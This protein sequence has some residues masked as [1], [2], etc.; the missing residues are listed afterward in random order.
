MPPA[1]PQIRFS[2][3]L[4]SWHHVV[5]DSDDFDPV[6]TSVA[7]YSNDP[8]GYAERYAGHLLDRPARF[9]SS[10]PQPS[11]IL[12]LGCGPGRDLALF[13]EAGHRPVGVEMNPDFVE[14]ARA[15]GEV[16]HADFRTI[17]QIFDAESFDGVWAQA[18]L[19]HLPDHEVLSVLADLRELLNPKGRLFACVPAIGTSGWAD[20]SDGRRWYTV[21][22][23]DTFLDAIRSAG[24][25]IDDVAYG[26][27]VEVWATAS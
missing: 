9:A 8:V 25:T 15:R 19:V 14:M 13:T 7:A 5:M 18:S 21:W 20:E 23:D 24:F 4:V 17:A 2:S 27:Y 22:P 3:S 26:P 12:D 1:L 6:R 16:I 11:R 10:L